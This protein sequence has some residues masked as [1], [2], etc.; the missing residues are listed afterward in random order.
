MVEHAAGS[1]VPDGPKEDRQLVILEDHRCMEPEEAALL[2]RAVLAEC[3]RNAAGDPV[4]RVHVRAVTFARLKLVLHV[5]LFGDAK[6][7]NARARAAVV[8]FGAVA[9]DALRGRK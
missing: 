7:K 2:M 1:A 6:E 3:S 8:G 5:S 9:R 4:H